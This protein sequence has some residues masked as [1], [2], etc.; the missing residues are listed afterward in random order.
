M[1]QNR[2]LLMAELMALPDDKAVK[3]RLLELIES[4][5]VTARLA[6]QGGIIYSSTADTNPALLSQALTA[7]Q[8]RAVQAANRAG[9]KPL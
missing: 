1:T 3:S 4:G 5:V 9:V 7:D 8:V 6:G 2:D